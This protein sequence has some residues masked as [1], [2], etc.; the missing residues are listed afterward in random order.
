[1]KTH[2]IPAILMFTFAAVTTHISHAQDNQNVSS[3]HTGQKK[4]G[5]NEVV[6][7]LSNKA[8]GEF[9]PIYDEQV[10][11]IVRMIN[12][13]NDVPGAIN[14]MVS[15]GVYFGSDI[16]PE[17]EE[18]LIRA[19]KGN[20]GLLNEIAK[21]ILVDL[22]KS[23]VT[24]IQEVNAILDQMEKGNGENIKKGIKTLASAQY[25]LRTG[26]DVTINKDKLE[27]WSEIGKIEGSRFTQL[28][29]SLIELG[30]Q[31]ELNE[32]GARHICKLLM[33]SEQGQIMNTIASLK[34][35]KW[36]CE[37]EFDSRELMVISN[38]IGNKYTEDKNMATTPNPSGSFMQPVAEKSKNY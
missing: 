8:V 2:I 24:S 33:A 11:Q 4:S 28:Y 17:E 23:P 3:D 37:G 5:F 1:M 19:S 7:A 26:Y 25:R 6:T 30:S 21:S 13:G 32:T 10:N 22:K 14:A 29:T 27:L 18:T 9:L 12:K 20:V 16:D 34:L 15:L 31:K 36:R 38:L 35:A